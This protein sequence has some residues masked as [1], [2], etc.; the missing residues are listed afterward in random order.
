MAR[1]NHT[2]NCA[3]RSE[4]QDGK[5]TEMI[6]EPV[7]QNVLRHSQAAQLELYF[8]GDMRDITAFF[9]AGGCFMQKVQRQ[10]IIDDNIE[11]LD[12]FLRY[13]EFIPTERSYMVKYASFEFIECYLQNRSLGEQAEE[14]ARNGRFQ[15]EFI[16]RIADKLTP[17]AR[18][19]C[20]G[21]HKIDAE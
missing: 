20:C 3:S 5:G 10:M 19:I 18:K 21:L 8:S 15:K 9:A 4:Q 17:K 6:K 14:L 11:V 2:N 1:K 7:P 13:W 16:A 12:K